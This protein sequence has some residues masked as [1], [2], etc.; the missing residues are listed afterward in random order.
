MAIIAKIVVSREMIIPYTGYQKNQQNNREIKPKVK[1][2]R[3]DFFSCIEKFLFKVFLP[4]TKYVFIL[5]RRKS[6]LRFFLGIYEIVDFC[7]EVEV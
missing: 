2:K 1:D 6:F 4:I 5:V 3:E 7:D